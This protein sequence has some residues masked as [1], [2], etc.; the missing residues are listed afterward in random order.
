MTPEQQA[1]QYA[2]WIGKL[3]DLKNKPPPIEIIDRVQN[4]LELGN[5]LVGI[6]VIG[7]A[8]YTC[9][10]EHYA[11]KSRTL[12]KAD[13][14]QLPDPDYDPTTDVCGRQCPVGLYKPTNL[15][16]QDEIQGNQG[17]YL[18]K[19]FTTIFNI[20][21]PHRT[22][23]NNAL[24]RYNL[25]GVIPAILDRA[26]F[27]PKQ[28]LI[29]VPHV[30]TANQM[31][32]QGY[33]FDKA[34]NAYAKN[35]DGSYITEAQVQ[36]APKAAPAMPAL[37]TLPAMPTAPVAQAIPGLPALPMPMAAAAPAIP[38][39]PAAP[40]LPAA[41]AAPAVAKEA[42]PE[43][44]KAK[45]YLEK[46]LAI[47]NEELGEDDSAPAAPKVKMTVTPDNPATDSEMVKMFRAHAAHNFTGIP[48][49]SKELLGQYFLN[50]AT[51][52]DLK[53]MLSILKVDY[54][55]YTEDRFGVTGR[56]VISRNLFKPEGVGRPKKA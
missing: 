25:M 11:P 38:A 22:N 32:H 4:D 27:K 48:N 5:V 16:Q 14:G 51:V 49:F 12:I 37:P 42:N 10:G 45:G 6:D 34:A 26:F 29:M 35:A 55:E 21:L 54:S 23:P 17:C 18:L 46:A 24:I 44:E 40:G 8:N 50:N 43:L 56:S 31:I 19:L 39:M 3:R 15:I 33:V 2:E 41:P 7:E 9:F 53:K 1:G 20:P 47:I 52:E 30:L 28:D 13:G 36:A